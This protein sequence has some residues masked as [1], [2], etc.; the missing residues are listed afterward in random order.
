MKTEM[1]LALMYILGSALIVGACVAS[2][3]IEIYKEEL[4]HIILLVRK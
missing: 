3:A 1:K 2:V 4:V